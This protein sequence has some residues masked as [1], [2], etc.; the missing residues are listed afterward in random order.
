M[1]IGLYTSTR[2]LEQKKQAI[3][4]AI[5]R[6]GVEATVIHDELLTRPSSPEQAFGFEELFKRAKFYA[7]EA[8][9]HDGVDIG[10]GIEN[11]LS[12]IYS[13]NQWYYTI[14]VSLHTK[15][16]E[17]TASFTPGISVPEQMVK[18][19]QQNH[20]KLDALTKRFT[21][22]DD[23]VIYFSSR[24]LTRKDLMIPA[25]LLAFSNLGLG[26]GKAGSPPAYR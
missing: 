16:G 20:L 8:V 3:E 9:K 4:E 13:A 12:F 23:P 10:V 14:C 11:S 17:E 5:R 21:G 19:V 1:T 2:Y 25:A 7:R 18:E 6:L 22:E 15:Y 24:A 26:K